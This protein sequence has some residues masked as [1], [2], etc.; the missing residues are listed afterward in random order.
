[1]TQLLFD[2]GVKEVV[3]IFMLGF[4]FITAI[5]VYALEKIL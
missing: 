4:L 2:L 3:I 5:L 1:M